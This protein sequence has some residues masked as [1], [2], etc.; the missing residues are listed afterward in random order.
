MASR[1]KLRSTVLGGEEDVLIR[2]DMKACGS[3]IS[4]DRVQKLPFLVD[5]GCC[6]SCVCHHIMSHIGLV[7]YSYMPPL[8]QMQF[9]QFL[10]QL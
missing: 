1:K 5:I 10:V 8:T 2:F 7:T 6:L 9:W 3:P 4:K